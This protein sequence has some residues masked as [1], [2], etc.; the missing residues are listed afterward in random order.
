MHGDL[1]IPRDL[2]PAA[3]ILL[4]ALQVRGD[5]EALVLGEDLRRP[6]TIKAEASVD[7]AVSDCAAAGQKAG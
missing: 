3:G 7:E 5:Q 1:G 6:M 2:E 4:R